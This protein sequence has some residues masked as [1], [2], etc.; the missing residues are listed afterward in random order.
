M[1]QRHCRYCN[2]WHKLDAWPHDCMP[3]QKARSPLK[4]PNLN[5]DTMKAVQS[6][7]SG[8]YY[9]SKSELR[10]EYKQLGMI[11]V[12]DD[13]S[14]LNPKPFKAPKP[15]RKEIQ[16]SIARAMEKVGLNGF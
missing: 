2:G 15:D 14:I 5:L 10:K 8:K 3:P 9:D 13:S 16:A 1:R 4:T 7:A 11:E 12:G 6:Q